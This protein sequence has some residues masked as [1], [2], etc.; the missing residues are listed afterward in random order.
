MAP[1]SGVS[2]SLSLAT[3]SLEV[4]ES[5]RHIYGADDLDQRLSVSSSVGSNSCK[6]LV[7]IYLA[8]AQYFVILYWEGWFSPSPPQ[9]KLICFSYA[10]LL[11]VVEWR[12]N[13]LFLT[14]ELANKAEL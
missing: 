9:N 2:N 7:S 8:F 4:G 10:V 6:L 14:S 5:H 13:I 11:F 3:R 12:Q 1:N